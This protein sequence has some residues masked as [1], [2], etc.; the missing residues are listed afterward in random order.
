MEN[1]NTCN[2]KS[3]QGLNGNRQKDVLNYEL[4]V[5]YI[6]FPVIEHYNSQVYITNSI[7]LRLFRA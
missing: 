5:S 2:S 1:R 7:I 6:V 4:K 3:D